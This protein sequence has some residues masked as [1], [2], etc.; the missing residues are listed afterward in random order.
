MEQRNYGTGDCGAKR[1]RAH[2]ACRNRIDTIYTTQGNEEDD[3]KL[4]EAVGLRD[5]VVTATNISFGSELVTT[6]DG[7]FY[8]DDYAVLMV[9]EPFDDLKEVSSSGHI[10]AMLD[11]DGI[12][13]HAIWSVE[14]DDGYDYPSFNQVIYKKYMEY[15]GNEEY[16]SPP[17][18]ALDRWYLP[19]TSKPMS[20]DS[21][22]SIYDLVEGNLDPDLFKDK[23]VLIGPYA[24]GMNDEYL[25]AIDYATKMYGVE[26]QANAIA[27][28]LSGDLKTEIV[29]ADTIVILVIITFFML[30]MLYE[31]KMLFCTILWVLMSVLWVATCIIMWQFDYVLQIYYPLVSMLI[32]YIGSVAVN[33]LKSTI[34]KMHVTNTFKRY[35]SPHVVARIVEHNK[36]AS[37]LGGTLKNI[38]VL[39]ADIRGFTTL[40]EILTPNEVAVML[41]KYLSMMSECVL[42]NEGTLDKFTGDGVMA[43]WG[44]PLIQ[45]D[46]AFKAISCA[47][48]MIKRSKKLNAE[49]MEKYD[50]NIGIGIGINFGSAVVGNFGSVNRMDYTAI[51]DTVNVASRI[52]SNT[53]AGQ[54]LLSASVV[55]MLDSRVKIVPE[56]EKIYLKG[57]KEAAEVY[58]LLVD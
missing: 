16:L 10:N 33:Y 17:T 36:D 20:Y 50:Y 22:F 39:F 5:N 27:A 32:C 29:Y 44:A 41:N 25:T 48:Q 6:E 28:L 47:G 40:A 34:E 15:I 35:V 8:M 14:L 12:L 1:K 23:I 56:G 53:K 11:T 7:D 54:V 2:S 31:R 55:E 3:K 42:E 30:F 4:V 26:Y 57:K 58:S 13:R 49:V 21:G 38:T 24:L 19:F 18:D 46:I 51:G 52:E 37:E 43:F 45:E 9:E